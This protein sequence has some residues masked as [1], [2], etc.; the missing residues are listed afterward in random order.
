METRILK[1][2]IYRSLLVA[3]LPLMALAFFVAVKLVSASG[4]D[5]NANGGDWPMWGGTPGRNIV[6]PMK[7]LPAT[8]DVAKKTNVKWVATLGSQSY[9]NPVV[10]GG[11]IFLGTNNEGLRDPK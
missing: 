7:G 3:A 2:K 6:S 4:A 10:S 8:W 1:R 11:L 5:A 9:G